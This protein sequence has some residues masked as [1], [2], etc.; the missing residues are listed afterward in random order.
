M[1]EISRKWSN[2]ILGVVDLVNP[3]TGDI[4]Y[5]VPNGSNYYWELGGKVLGTETHTSPG[6]GA[7]ELQN[8][9]DLIKRRLPQ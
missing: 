3:T 9:D 1:D 5:S 6:I 8:L 4:R 2:A 7:L